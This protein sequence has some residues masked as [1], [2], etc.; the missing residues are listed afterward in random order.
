MEY[1]LLAESDPVKLSLN[2]NRNLENGWVLYGNPSIQVGPQNSLWHYQAI[3]HNTMEQNLQQPTT[4]QMVGAE[5]PQINQ[6]STCANKDMFYVTNTPCGRC[7][8]FSNWR[9]IG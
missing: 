8:D 9:R 5:P 1:L 4:E 2:V 6:C 3:V 7:V